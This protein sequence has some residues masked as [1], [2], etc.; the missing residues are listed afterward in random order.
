MVSVVTNLDTVVQDYL[1]D[2]AFQKERDLNAKQRDETIPHY[3]HVVTQFANGTFNLEALSNALKT[4]HKDTFWGLH[5]SGL[6]L[7]IYKLILH[8]LPHSAVSI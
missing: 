7:E 5:G 3:Q 1:N 4:L 8:H 2:V 6:L